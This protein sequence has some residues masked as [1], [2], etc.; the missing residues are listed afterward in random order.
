MKYFIIL[1]LTFSIPNFV[2]CDDIWQCS[3]IEG[4]DT[5]AT[6]KELGCYTDNTNLIVKKFYY[7]RYFRSNWIEAQMI[8][9]SYDMELARFET[10]DEVNDVFAFLKN[11]SD[12][13]FQNG[14]WI[15]V[16]G[17]ASTPGS[18]TSWYWTQTGV[19]VSFDIP[20]ATSNP[21]GGHEQCLSIGKHGFGYPLSF[22]DVPYEGY[23]NIFLCQKTKIKY[24]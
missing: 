24:Q 15:F 18:V 16:G 3:D 9:K 21:S 10:V 2:H 19:K 5:Q 4:P 20:W 7:P 22:N 8:C 1:I 13:V 6:F 17:I 14:Y 11:S 12:N 23:K